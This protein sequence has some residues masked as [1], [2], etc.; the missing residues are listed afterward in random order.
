MDEP[1]SVVTNR[2]SKLK[3]SLEKI[4]V[5]I[6]ASA[7]EMETINF[8][9]HVIDPDVKMGDPKTWNS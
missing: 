4:C 3:W 7:D 9:I 6:S 2:F 5:Q 1:V 8:V